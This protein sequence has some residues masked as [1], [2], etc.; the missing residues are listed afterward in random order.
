MDDLGPRAGGPFRH[1]VGHHVA[2]VVRA[3]VAYDDQVAPRECRLHARSLDD[4]VL[5]RPAQALRAQ[6][7]EPPGEHQRDEGDV[8]H[9][10]KPAPPSQ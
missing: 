1:P 2:D 5:G 9:D 3:L 8:A 7:E 4:H 6:V 10:P